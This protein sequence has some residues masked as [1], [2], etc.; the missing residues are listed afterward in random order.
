MPKKKSH[1]RSLIRI[2]EYGI[3]GGAWFWSGFAMFAVLYSGLK[4]PVIPAKIT[5]YIFGLLVNFVL[6]RFWVFGDKQPKQELDKV[7][8]RYVLLSALNLC[9]DTGIVYGLDRIGINPYIGQFVSAGF[10][11]VWNYIWY[12][13]WVFT[14]KRTP[15]TKRPAA[16]ALHRSKHVRYHSNR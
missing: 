11:T 14:K 1:K 4:W 5:A 9:I 2:I 10:F 15:G 12:H 16:P 8:L 7:T 3:S 13:L 6:E